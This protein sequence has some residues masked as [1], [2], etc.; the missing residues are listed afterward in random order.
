MHVSLDF[1]SLVRKGGFETANAVPTI[2][3][4]TMPPPELSGQR[5]V[6]SA[7]S[8][9]IPARRAGNSVDGLSQVQDR[10]IGVDGGLDQTG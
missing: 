2:A 8:P 7:G 1:V 6:D 4:R 5:L 10:L 3:T 9:A